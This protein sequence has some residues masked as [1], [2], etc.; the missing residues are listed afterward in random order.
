[1]RVAYLLADPGIPV[2]GTKGASVHVGEV[3]RALAAE[4]AS[5]TLVA[6]AVQ[7]AAPP[8]VG[9]LH[10][11]PG[12]VP[13]GPTGEPARI[14][15]A[16]DFEQRAASA[17]AEI[18]PD[19][20]YERLS[21]FFSG[22]GELA[23]S[24][25]AA[26]LLEV[27]APVAAERERHFGLVRREAADR[28]ERLAIEGAHVLAVSVPLAAWALERKAASVEV[29]TNGVDAARF[30][31]ELRR[32]EG[33][34][35]RRSLCGGDAEV[36][37]FVGSLKPWH[38]VDVLLEAVRRL[39][40]S[41][42]RLRLLVVGDGPMRPSLEEFTR[43][44]GLE[45]V[46]T[47]AG[48][49]P[50]AA[51]PGHLAALEI[52][53]A[54]FLPAEEFYFS[55]LKVVEAM[56]AGRPVVASRLSTVESMLG[57]TGVLV[58]PGDPAAL[59]AGLDRLLGDPALARSLGERARKRCLRELRWDAVARRILARVDELSPRASSRAGSPK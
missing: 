12:P 58:E 28:H 6:Q 33:S 38:G 41:R 19:L 21:L 10:L 39:K 27:N 14:E 30:D 13:S 54:P 46:V 50:Y 57:G 47:F 32:D 3:C 22:G 52:A 20:V 17:L 35:L 59:A 37:G 15:A 49:V 36:V 25:R 43:R 23:R 7:G 24:L 4:G 56:A 51:V 45:A 48:A 18:E 31:P 55:P 11:D 42:P 44:A 29:V 16:R 34:E 1:M 5:V 2:G 8:K 9:L 53:T 40:G 26:R